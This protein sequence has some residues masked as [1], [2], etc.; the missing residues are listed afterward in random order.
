MRVEVGV[1]IRLVGRER[2][3]AVTVGGTG[4]T[5]RTAAGTRRIGPE[6]SV[7]SRP[8]RPHRVGT[9][10]DAAAVRIPLPGRTTG[11][12]GPHRRR[13]CP[14]RGRGWA[15]D[16]ARRRTPLTNDVDPSDLATAHLDVAGAVAVVRRGR[17][18]TQPR[19]QLGGDDGGPGPRRTPGLRRADAGDVPGTA[20]TSRSGCGGS[21]G[22][23]GIH[24]SGRSRVGH[25]L[26]ARCRDREE[27]VEAA[28]GAVGRDGDASIPGPASAP[29]G[30]GVPADAAPAN[31]ASSTREAGGTAGPSLSGITSDT[32]EWSRRPRSRRWS[33]TSR[34]VSLGAGALERRRRHGDDDVSARKASSTS[35]RA[36]A[37]ATV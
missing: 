35:R 14:R 15:L 34:A 5:G 20:Y 22:S 1:V 36:K 11:A 6:R 29:G 24:L 12:P 31:A 7:T 3:H 2:R 23:T 16:P 13:T 19:D 33:W 28:P 37:P 9:A 26:R 30:T 21:A 18:A 32:V 25:D 4:V 10:V 17:P 8:R 27:Q